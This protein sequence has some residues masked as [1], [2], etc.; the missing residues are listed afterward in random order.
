MTTEARD[1]ARIF[2]DIHVL[3]TPKPNV[4][5]LLEVLEIMRQR[6]LDGTLVAFTAAGLADDDT[7]YA[8]AASSKRVTRLRMMGAIAHL[9]HSYHNGDVVDGHDPEAG[10]PKAS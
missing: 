5:N 9:Q 7:C 2:C 10:E 8:Y 1:M 3:E 6:V 4:D